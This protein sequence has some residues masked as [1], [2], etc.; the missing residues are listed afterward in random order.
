MKIKFTD[1]D[2]SG[3]KQNKV[4]KFSILFV[5]IVL[6]LLGSSGFIIDLFFPASSNSFHNIAGYSNGG[7][8][9]GGAVLLVCFYG[10]T[11]S[12]NK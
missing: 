7:R 11:K 1:S 8:F 4:L 3:F 9:L 5:G 10:L 6:I 12:S 2:P